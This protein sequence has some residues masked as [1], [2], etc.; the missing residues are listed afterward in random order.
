MVSTDDGFSLTDT[1]GNLLDLTSILLTEGVTYRFIIVGDSPFCVSLVD[2]VSLN[3]VSKGPLILNVDE[4]FPKTVRFLVNRED[5]FRD[6]FDV[7]V[8]KS[9]N[10]SAGHRISAAS[11]ATIGAILMWMLL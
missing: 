5:G 9:G 8:I 3:C 4:Y 2:Q 11:G 10:G 1:N 6:A 7:D